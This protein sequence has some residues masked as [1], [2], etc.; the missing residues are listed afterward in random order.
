MGY[1]FG[2]GGYGAADGVVL[3]FLLHPECG[4]EQHF[5]GIYSSGDVGFGAPNNHTIIAAFGNVDEHIRVC[6]LTR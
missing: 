3:V 2:I 4:H 1:P 5:V 6:L